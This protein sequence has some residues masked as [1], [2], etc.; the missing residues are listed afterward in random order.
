MSDNVLRDV[1]GIR[2]TVHDEQGE[3]LW[4]A[5]GDGGMSGLTRSELESMRG[6]TR[7]ETAGEKLVMLAEAVI[8]AK[9][10]YDNTNSQHRAAFEIAGVV[11][12]NTTAEFMAAATP[13]AIVSLAREMWVAGHE[14]GYQ[15]CR[16]VLDD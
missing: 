14:K 5:D 4:V 12:D 16:A 10:V 9:R 6:P 1:Q 2:W 3:E 15:A 11:L 8:A 13:D 7:E